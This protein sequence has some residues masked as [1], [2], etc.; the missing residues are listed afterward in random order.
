MWN[1]GRARPWGPPAIVSSSKVIRVGVSTAASS[2]M[3][4]QTSGC[5]RLRSMLSHCAAI[6]WVLSETPAAPRLPESS[7]A[8][9][10]SASVSGIRPTLRRVKRVVESSPIGA[11]YQMTR[12][13]SKRYP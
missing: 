9:N 1:R 4:A 11:S 10:S 6:S 8:L 2:A 7:R 3:N 13:L 5:C 12:T